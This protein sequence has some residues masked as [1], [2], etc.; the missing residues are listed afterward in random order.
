MK[1][2]KWVVNLLLFITILVGGG[3]ALN[4]I[5]IVLKM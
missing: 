1:R 2:Y 5:T 4:A 3:F